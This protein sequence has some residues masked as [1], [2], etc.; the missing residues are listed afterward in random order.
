MTPFLHRL[1]L[2]LP[3]LTASCAGLQRVDQGTLQPQTVSGPCQV[4]KFFLVNLTAVPTDLTVTANGQACSFT[5]INPDL[6]IFNTAA[7]V[8]ERPSHGQATS[9]LL[10]GGVQAGVSYTPEPGYTGKD[11]FTVTLEPADRAIRLNVT[12]QPG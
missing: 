10:R 2:A 9:G 5:L 1:C 7:L 4:K 11:T 8:T 12:V 3:L 6:Q